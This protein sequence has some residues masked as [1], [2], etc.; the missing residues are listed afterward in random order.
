MVG[1]AGWMLGQALEHSIADLRRYEWWIVGVLT[2][3][4]LVIAGFRWRAWQAVRPEP[5][6]PPD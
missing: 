5:D 3:I 1:T 6:G 2:V 4:A